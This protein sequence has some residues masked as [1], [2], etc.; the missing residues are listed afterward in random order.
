MKRIC[1]F[2]PT[3]NGGHALY[4]KEYVSALAPICEEFQVE[5]ITSSD[6]GPSYRD[7]AYTINDFLPPQP[8]KETFG[9]KF[10]WAISRIFHYL[11]RERAFYRWIQKNSDVEAIH[12][13]EFTP[14][15]APHFFRKL[16]RDGKKL[17]YTVHNVR[18]HKYLPFIPKGWYD[19]WQHQAWLLCDGLFV[20]SQSLREQLSSLL[21]NGHPP[22]HVI[23]HG[24]WT[25]RDRAPLAPAARV[26][27]KEI[28]FFGALRKNKGLHLLLEAMKQLEGFRLLVAGY[29]SD[30]EYYQH[31]ILP[32]LAEGRRS[33]NIRIEPRFIGEDEIP[34]LFEASTLIAL[35]YTDFEAQSGVL[36]MAMA[37][38]LP[39][40]ASDKGAMKEVVQD[41]GIGEIVSELSPESLAAAIR[42]LYANISDGSL[43]DNFA[44]A[45]RKYSWKSTATVALSA[46][47]KDLSVPEH[48]Q[49]PA[50]LHA[51]AAK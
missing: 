9:S 31:T 15:L 24:A 3:A 39:I 10:S 34:S 17:Y 51:N 32:M 7:V 12:F 20:H 26:N 50:Q 47:A 35:P 5:L 21:G 45:K 37:Y 8:S 27:R 44:C 14:W 48:P 38:D 30:P 22:I 2:T 33:G 36:Y 13:Q 16:K 49:H 29:P 18:P 41:N 23:N 6:L 19:S 25:V 43:H 40:L 11:K 4:T 1:I 28:L 46:Y 42:R